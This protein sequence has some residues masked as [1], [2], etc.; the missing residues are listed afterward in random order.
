MEVLK[1]FIGNRNLTSRGGAIHQ[2]HMG[3]TYRPPT[4][5]TSTVFD[6]D[7]TFLAFAQ[8][9]IFRYEREGLCERDAI[10]VTLVTPADK[11]AFLESLDLRTVA[12]F[13]NDD[14]ESMDNSLI[15][16]TVRKTREIFRDT[17]KLLWRESITGYEGHTSS[18]FQGGEEGIVEGNGVCFSRLKTPRS[19]HS[20]IRSIL[21]ESSYTHNQNIAI[22]PKS[23][24]RQ[25]RRFFPDSTEP[26]RFRSRIRL[27]FKLSSTAPVKSLTLDGFPSP[28][29]SY[30]PPSPIATY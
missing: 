19:L 25:R 29:G 26:P 30:A 14:E 28:R 18:E 2:R 20:P 11:Q 13:F 5:V 21:T 1:N 16:E 24:G 6:N 3:S 8:D 4:V 15:N 22:R 17:L 7:D 10:N 27:D 23:S 9:M 12:T